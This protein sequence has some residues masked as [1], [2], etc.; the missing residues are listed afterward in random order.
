MEDNSTIIMSIW[1]YKNTRVMCCNPIPNPCGYSN[2]ISWHAKGCHQSCRRIAFKPQTGPVLK[3]RVQRPGEVHG[4][5]GDDKSRGRLRLTLLI[6]SL[7]GHQE[8]SVW[9]LHY[10]MYM[11]YACLSNY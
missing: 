9:C 4:T 5:A 1:I 6:F 10:L 3:L 2:L 8:P 7:P 11:Y